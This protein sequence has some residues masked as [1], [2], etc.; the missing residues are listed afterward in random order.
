MVGNI[1][2]GKTTL[3]KEYQKKG[4]VVIARDMLRY[5]IGG[6]VYIYNLEYEPIIFE[7]GLCML[8]AFME[9]GVNIVVDEVGLSKSMRMRYIVPAKDYG[10]I[11]T[12]HELPK[13]SMEESVNRRLN[14]PHG[15]PDRELWEGVWKKFNVMYEEP[16]FEGGFNNII[17]T[18]A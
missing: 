5:A 11:I 14:N 7:T 17:R 9:L 2:S 15:Q 8:E 12:C 18:V 4:Y 10:Y 16:T 13:L 3:V 6:G 1:G